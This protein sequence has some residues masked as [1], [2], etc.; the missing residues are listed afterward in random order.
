MLDSGVKE[1]RTFQRNM[2]YYH[3]II[4]NNTIDE[5]IDERLSQKFENMNSALNDS[6]PSALDY[7]QNSANTVDVNDHSAKNDLI[8][9]VT[10]LENTLESNTNDN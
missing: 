2:V 4:A 1:E 6:W 8:S 7:D 9:L 3:I 5:S 10:S